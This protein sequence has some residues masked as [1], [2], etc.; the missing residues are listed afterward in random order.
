MRGRREP[1]S[2]MRSYKFE[3]AIR[4]CATAAGGVVSGIRSL[5]CCPFRL[6]G[7]VSKILFRLEEWSSFF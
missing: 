6:M 4:L 7:R 1:I 3:G 5:R 2:R